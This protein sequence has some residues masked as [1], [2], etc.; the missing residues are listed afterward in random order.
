MLW[1][2]PQNEDAIPSQAGRR[3][4]R[5]SGAKGTDTRSLHGLRQPP[6]QRHLALRAIAA[7]L[8]EQG[9]S[10]SGDAAVAAAE[11]VLRQA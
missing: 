5:Q 4:L 9:L 6:R 3:R 8:R 10:V 1:Y 2:V 7:M 11:A